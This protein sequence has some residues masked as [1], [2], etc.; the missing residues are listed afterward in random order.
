[1]SVSIKVEGLSDLEEKLEQLGAVAGLKVLQSASRSACKP[2]LERARELVPVETGVLRDSLRIAVVRVR[3]GSVVISAGLKNRPVAVKN[4]IVDDYGNVVVV[5]TGEKID[6][7][8]RLHFT[9]FGT[10]KSAAHPFLRPAFDQMHGEMLAALKEGL[11]GAIA[12]AARKQ[13]DKEAPLT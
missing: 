3:S 11:G 9:E 12:R 5:K 13:L 6:A 1:M 2:L 7:G 4:E 8:W 10:S